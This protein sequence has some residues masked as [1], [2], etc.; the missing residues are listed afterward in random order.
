MAT[1][2]RTYIVPLRRTFARAPRY[3][4]SK[5]AMTALKAFITRHMKGTDVKIGRHLNE[6]VWENGIRNPPHHVKI[7]AIRD[8]EG[9]VKAEL[10][11]FKYEEMT[12]EEM[13]KAAKAKKPAK[14]EAIDKDKIVEKVKQ[15]PELAESAVKKPKAIKEEE[16]LEEM[17]D[18]LVKEEMDQHG[19]LEREE[20]IKETIDEIKKVEPAAK[21]PA[22]AKPKKE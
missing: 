20:E 2:E 7:S 11:G 18:K 22:K 10:F 8:D 13:E 16:R 12:K 14:T 5:R 19:N 3:K 6:F 1:L 9:I 21:K 15:K 4:R 17:D